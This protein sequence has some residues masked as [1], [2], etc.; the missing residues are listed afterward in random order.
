MQE[1][2]RRE[3]W[4]TGGAAVVAITIA[5][6]MCSAQAQ[7]VKREIVQ[8]GWEA[9]YTFSPAVVT[10]G[11]KIVWVAGHGGFVDDNNKSLAGDFDAQARQAFKNI[12][13][14]LAKAGATLNDVV[15]MTVYISDVR[16]SKR[17]TEIRAEFYPKDFP[18]STLITTGFALPEMMVEITPVAVVAK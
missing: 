7:G 1:R 13:R 14:T 3:S 16:F 15:T 17:F 5:A 4:L 10:E 6:M 2:I 8:P 12:Q 9:K 18:A 11:G